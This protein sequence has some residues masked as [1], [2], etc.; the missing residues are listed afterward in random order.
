M[1]A[2]GSQWKHWDRDRFGQELLSAVPDTSVRRPDSAATFVELISQLFV[3][4]NLADPSVEEAFDQQL[5]AIDRRFPDATAEQHLRAVHHL[6][7]A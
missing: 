1:E 2:L 3:Q 4:F 6:A 7:L 5:Q